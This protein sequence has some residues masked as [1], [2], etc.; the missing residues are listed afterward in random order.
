MTGSN[1]CNGGA[2]ETPLLPFREGL[3]SCQV[4][5]HNQ[6]DDTLLGTNQDIYPRGTTVTFDIKCFPHDI[7]SIGFR[8][9]ITFWL[10]E[11]GLQQI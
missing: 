2:S 6:T 9:F 3:A 5:P 7:S 4:R 11:R 10:F 1:N 8:D